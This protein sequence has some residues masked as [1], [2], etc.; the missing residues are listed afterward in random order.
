MEFTS[1]CWKDNFST[2]FSKLPYQKVSYCSTWSINTSTCQINHRTGQS[3][4]GKK[5]KKS[6]TLPVFSAIVAILSSQISSA[7]PGHKKRNPTKKLSSEVVRRR[8][9]KL[10]L[11]VGKEDHHSDRVSSDLAL[12]AQAST[13]EHLSP[14]LPSL[15]WSSQRKGRFLPKAEAG[16]AWGPPPSL[17]CSVT[18]D[19]NL[20]EPTLHLNPGWEHL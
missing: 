15:P 17:S 7:T 11:T 14:S 9:M 1:F 3:I 13:R 12:P 4:L 2:S 16:W 20:Q 5:K 18:P 19:Q 8:E 10:P 6:A